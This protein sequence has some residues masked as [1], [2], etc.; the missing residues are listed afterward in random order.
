MRKVM[1]MSDQQPR[2]GTSRRL[3]ERESDIG[4]SLA[5]H[6][7]QYATDDPALAARRDHLAELAEQHD[8]LAEQHE[9]VRPPAGPDGPF[10]QQVPAEPP[11]AVSEDE[12][13]WEELPQG[14]VHVL[15]KDGDEA[16]NRGG[17]WT[18]FYK[19]GR[20]PQQFGHAFFAA[21]HK[22]FRPVPSGG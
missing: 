22:P 5:A 11:A 15:T 13:I 2:Q 9:A 1:T 20:P 6:V 16:R 8:R 4:G 18:V 17:L 10:G 3:P 19:D 21:S 7:R 12:E 14:A